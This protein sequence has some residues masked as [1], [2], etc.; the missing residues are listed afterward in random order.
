MPRLSPCI[1][2]APRF[3]I[4]RP[5]FAIPRHPRANFPSPFHLPT[6]AMS[7]TT[8]PLPAIS[9]SSNSDPDA[10][11]AALPPLLE[12][13][14]LTPTNAGLQR[15][16]KFKTFKKTW[17]FMDAVAA[18][19]ARTKHHPEWSNVCPFSL[20]LSPLPLLPTSSKQAASQLIKQQESNTNTPRS[21]TQP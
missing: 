7:S 19:A 16:F 12:R 15:S 20:S 2:Q 3:T 18:E 1:L 8:P 13:W 21:T 10:V 4:S 17:A 6:R 5:L 11:T 14:S 9:V